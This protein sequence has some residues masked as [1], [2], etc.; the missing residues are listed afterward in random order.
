L[1]S[2]FSKKQF[3]YFILT[4]GFAAV[5][6]FCSRIFFNQWVPFSDAIVYAYF[7]GMITAYLLAKLFVF[8]NSQQSIS[9]SLVFFFL[10]N[11][12]AVGQT[13]IISMGLINYILPYFNIINYAREIAHGFGILLPVFT[14]YLGH[15]HLS[16]R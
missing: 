5:V 16:F 11:V 4:G 6:N 12:V 1:I 9:K 3:L 10:V 13:W 7:T 15:K 8:K 2:H 14:S